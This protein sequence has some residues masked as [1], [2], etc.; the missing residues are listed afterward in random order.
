MSPPQVICST[1]TEHPQTFQPNVGR[2]Y[3]YEKKFGKDLHG[4]YVFG[5]DSKSARDSVIRE[6]RPAPAGVLQ[7]RQGLR[8][9]RQRPAVAVHAGRAGDEEQGLELRPGNPSRRSRCPCARR[10]LCRTSPV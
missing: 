4:V 1:A 7:V 3:Y 8:P 5:N 10:P 6:Q 9:A 2:G